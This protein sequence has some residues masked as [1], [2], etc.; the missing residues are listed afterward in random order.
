MKYEGL[1]LW[2][3]VWFLSFLKK[4]VIKIY[5]LGNQTQCIQEQ[6]YYP[7][8]WLNI[9]KMIAIGCQ[10]RTTTNWKLK[11]QRIT[12]LTLRNSSPVTKSEGGG[13]YVSERSISRFIFRSSRLKV[14]K[15]SK[16]GSPYDSNGWVKMW[17][18]CNMSVDSVL[19]IRSLHTPFVCQ[20]KRVGNGC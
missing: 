20:R 11:L 5:I 10:T 18:I 4:S 13:L 3:D 8:K 14:N 1:V 17:Y 16:H 2:L 6:V 9:A 12:L 7:C 19:K 15:S